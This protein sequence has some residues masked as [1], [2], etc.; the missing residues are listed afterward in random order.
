MS[1]ARGPLHTTT[2][3]LFQK[4]VLLRILGSPTRR[5]PS[6]AQTR[7][8]GA[9]SRVEVRETTGDLAPRSAAA[10][11]GRRQPADGAP[12]EAPHPAAPLAR[13]RAMTSSPRFELLYFPVRGRGEQI[14]LMF[15]CAQVPFTDTAV[16]D[17]PASRASMPLG[18]LPVLRERSE[19]VPPRD[20]RARRRATPPRCWP[21]R[22]GR[23][24]ARSCAL[25]RAG[26]S[27]PGAAPAGPRSPRA[28]TSTHWGRRGRR[29]ASVR[30]V[31]MV[32]KG[33]AAGAAA[34][35]V[36][37][38]ARGQRRASR[39]MGRRS[40]GPPKDT[41]GPDPEWRAC[42]RPTPRSG[43]QA[44][45]PGRCRPAADRRPG[46]DSLWTPCQFYCE[47]TRTVIEVWGRLIGK[48]LPGTGTAGRLV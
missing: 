16:T 47:K 2:C 48:T 11:G 40:V 23:Q 22:A 4:L 34:W 3:L 7:L 24:G 41:S 44:T 20:R 12:R 45:T 18:Q 9:P 35:L 31:C 21:C 5:C 15:A 32:C 46:V 8:G 33:R 39:P 13:R 37:G 1:Q 42:S 10:R 25:R 28:T 30:V 29:C 26:S 6:R 38:G 36:A 19:E 27:P 14:R 43:W 17:W